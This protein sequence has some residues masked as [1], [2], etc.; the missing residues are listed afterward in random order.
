MLSRYT[1][2]R[3]AF[4]LA[5]SVFIG[6][7]AY[8]TGAALSGPLGMDEIALAWTFLLMFCGLWGWHADLAFNRISRLFAAKE[9]K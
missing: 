3:F 4:M 2:Y 6:P 7:I 5:I 1:I 8:K 9:S